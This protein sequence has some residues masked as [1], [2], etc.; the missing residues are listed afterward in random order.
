MN[1]STLNFEKYNLLSR[2]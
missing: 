2:H 1:D